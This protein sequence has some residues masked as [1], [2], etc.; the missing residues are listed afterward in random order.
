MAQ[1]TTT[2]GILPVLRADAA[3]FEKSFEKR[4]RRGTRSSSA[5]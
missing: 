3:G 1:R 2:K 4:S 5:S